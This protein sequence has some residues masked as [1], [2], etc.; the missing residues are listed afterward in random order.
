M[1]TRNRKPHLVKRAD[2]L[3]LAIDRMGG[4]KQLARRLAPQDVPV[5]DLVGRVRLPALELLQLAYFCFQKS[6]QG[7]DIDAMPFLDGLGA[8]KLLEHAGKSLPQKVPRLAS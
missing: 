3:V 7:I 2:D 4:R 5:V 8:D 1:R 6:F